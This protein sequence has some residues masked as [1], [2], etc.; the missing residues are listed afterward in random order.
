MRIDTMTRFNLAMAERPHMRQLKPAALLASVLALAACATVPPDGG[1]SRL[2]QMGSSP[3]AAALP[4]PR[5]GVDTSAEITQL[6]KAPLTLDAAV[7]VALLNNPGLQLALGSDGVNISDAVI[8]TPAKL[9]ARQEMTLLAA[10]ARKA[11]IRAVAAE[12]SAR[13]LADAKE[14]A[15]AGGELARRLARVGNWSKLQRTREQLMLAE[16]ANELARAQEAAFSA[17]EKLTVI[18][19][20]WGE[21]AQFQLPDRLPELPKDARDLPDIETRVMQARQDVQLAAAQWRQQR[22]KPMEAGPDGLWDALRDSARVRELAVKARSEA[23]EGYQRYRSRHDLARHYLDH[24]VP[25]RQFVS[26]EMLLRY[27]GMLSSVFDVLNDT[28]AQALSVNQAINAERDF[29]LAETD[30]QTLLAGVSPGPFD[31]EPG[32][33]SAGGGGAAPAGH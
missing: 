9:K 29:W 13:Y 26:D 30:L 7:R 15:E 1:I 10:G 5:P 28:R 12:Q 18:L 14:A 6:L 4:A 8:N 19:G 3:S 11:W 17:R 20:V 22:A 23:R 32:A 24:V 27:N 2:Q 21:H 31:G 16:A 33:S 25:L